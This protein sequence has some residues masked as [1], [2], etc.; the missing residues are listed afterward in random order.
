MAYM[1]ENLA[2]TIERVVKSNQHYDAVM[3]L[4][5]TADTLNGASKGIY[6]LATMLM[7]G[8]DEDK[9]HIHDICVKEFANAKEIDRVAK[10]FM[11]K[12]HEAGGE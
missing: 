9:Q 3:S 2:Q 8:Y 6:K 11:D 5:Y 4:K 10:M 7:F 1:E 12:Y